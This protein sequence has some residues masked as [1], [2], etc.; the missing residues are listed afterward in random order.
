VTYRNTVDFHYIHGVLTSDLA[1][2][3]IM[4][5]GD[6]DYQNTAYLVFPGS[7]DYPGLSPDT[8]H[9][10]MRGMLMTQGNDIG[11]LFSQ[12]I[13]KVRREGIGNDNGITAFNPEARMTQPGDIHVTNVSQPTSMVKKA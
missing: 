11:R 1:A 10:R 2:L 9:V 12:G 5:R 4:E 6:T 13:A 3:R 8:L 7:P